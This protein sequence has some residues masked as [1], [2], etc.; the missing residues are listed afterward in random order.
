VHGF[1]HYI[2]HGSEFDQRATQYLFDSDALSLL[3]EYGEPTLVTL[4][5]PGEIAFAAAN[6]ALVLVRDMPNLVREVLTSWAYWLAYPKF[7]PATLEVDCG[8]VFNHDVPAQ[9]IVKI[10]RITIPSSASDPDS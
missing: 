9:W 3:A 2:T 8:F 5:I 6:P 4:A 7:T 1:S 10:E